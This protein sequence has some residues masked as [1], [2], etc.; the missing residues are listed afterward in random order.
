MALQTNA[1]WLQTVTAVV[2]GMVYGACRLRQIRYDR[3][4]GGGAS[5]LDPCASGELC[6]EVCVIWVRASRQTRASVK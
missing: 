2:G 1:A 5:L 3:R 4:R 6:P